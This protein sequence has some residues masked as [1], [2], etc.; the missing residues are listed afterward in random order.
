MPDHWPIAKDEVH[1]VGDAVAVVVASDRYTAQDALE[2]I[3][4]DYEPLDVVI[5]MEE[6]IKE[7]TPLVHEDLGTN[8]AFFWPLEVGDVDDAFE[9]ADVVVKQ[10]FIQQRLIPNAIEPRAVVA[11]PDPVNGGVVYIP[12]PRFPTS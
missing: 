11:Q 1:H 3:D 2:H 12:R 4:V 7:D 5:D 6:A 10:R 9:K 8:T